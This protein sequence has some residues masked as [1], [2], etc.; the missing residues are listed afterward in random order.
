M[1]PL[2]RVHNQEFA[3]VLFTFCIYEALNAHCMVDDF[4]GKQRLESL[5]EFWAVVLASEVCDIRT[6]FLSVQ[7]VTRLEYRFA[8]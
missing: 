8:T 5:C 3:I 7:P 1:Q 4:C 6:N 2:L